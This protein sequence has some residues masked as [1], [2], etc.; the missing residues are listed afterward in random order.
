M[1]G[2]HVCGLCGKPGIDDAHMHMHVLLRVGTK[3]IS[4]SE[5]GV[6]LAR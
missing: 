6:F 1:T 2:R 4:L 5:C 3:S